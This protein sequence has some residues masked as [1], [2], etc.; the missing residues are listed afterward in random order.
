MSFAEAFRLQKTITILTIIV[1][2][3]KKNVLLYDYPAGTESD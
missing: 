1:Q 3:Y 2:L